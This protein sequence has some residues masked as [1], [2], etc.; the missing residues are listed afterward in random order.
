MPAY[1]DTALEVLDAFGIEQAAVV[2][3]SLGGHV[4]IEMISRLPGMTGLLISGSP[5]VSKASEDDVKAGFFMTE[6]TALA[7]QET[8]TDAEAEAYARG[9]MGYEVP[10][11]Q[12]IVETI[13]RTDGRARANMFR[14][15]LDGVGDDQKEIVE[16][17]PLPICVANGASQ[18]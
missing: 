14:A 12:F 2:G 9:C 7:G 16:T 6:V 3:W 18:A 1:A 4:G 13:K 17:N 8:L 5:P 11:E 15:F 10:L